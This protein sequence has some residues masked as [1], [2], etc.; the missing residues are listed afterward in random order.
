MNNQQ[1]DSA[2]LPLALPVAGW[3]HALAAIK[4]E[5]DSRQPLPDILAALPANACHEVFAM[6][7][8]DSASMAGF[9]MML[10]LM[11]TGDAPCFFVRVAGRNGMLLYPAGLVE[12]GLDPARCF[13]VH[14][15]DLLSALRAT[16]DIA[17]S[18]AA[19]AVLVEV[20]GN[21]RLL[22]LTA[23]RRLALAAEK[24]GTLVLLLRSGAQ[25]TPSAAY[26]RWQVASAPSQPLLAN[27]PGVPA[28]AVTLLRHRRMQ[29]GRAARLIWNFEDQCFDEQDTITAPQRSG[30]E[31]ASGRASALATGRAAAP[32]TQPRSSRA[33]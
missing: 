12:L 7:K 30:G 2:R 13:N 16:A 15:P 23:S 22:D 8:G 24:S 10:A 5:P 21:P 3:G 18:G 19:G 32:H 33:A 14:A 1:S 27:A 31:A 11:L 4:T 9:A 17:R 25:A 28:F 20:E 26:S 29:A 6:V